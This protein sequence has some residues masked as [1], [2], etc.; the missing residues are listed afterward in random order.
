MKRFATSAEKG[1]RC[2]RSRGAAAKVWP[3]P[4]SRGQDAGAVYPVSPINNILVLGAGFV[5]LMLNLWVDA[6][7]I[8]AVAILNALLGFIQEGKAEKALN[9]IRNML[10]AEARVARGG[11][12][13][14]FLLPTS[15]FRETSCSSS[16]AIKFPPI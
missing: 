9:S 4:P 16:P 10:S 13:R 15:S 3:E 2:G 12:T 7:I 11:E 1:T 14:G 6:G 8:F 5:K